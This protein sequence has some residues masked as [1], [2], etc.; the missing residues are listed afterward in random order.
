MSTPKSYQFETLS[1]HAGQKP[2][3]EHGARAQLAFDWFL[4]RNRCGIP[5]YDF[6]TGGC[7]DGLGESGPSLNEGAESTLSFHRAKLLLDAA[8]L[9]IVARRPVRELAGVG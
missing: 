5:L 8:Q 2:D 1:L 6:T 3:P 7:G 9:P 4:G